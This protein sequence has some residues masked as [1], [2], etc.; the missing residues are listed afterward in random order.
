MKDIWIRIK[1]E[2]PAFWKRF[3]AIALSI[4][5]SA[6]ALW[7]INSGMGLE[8]PI[9]IITICKYTLAVCATIT[10]TATLT[11]V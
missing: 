7:G 1:S 8:L 6:A 9:I 11:K 4:G 3:R 10:G 2:T 5:G